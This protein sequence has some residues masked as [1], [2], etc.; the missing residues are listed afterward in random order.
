MPFPLTKGVLYMKVLKLIDDKLEEYL[1]VVLTVAMTALI[2]IQ[3]VMRYVFH[4]SPA[5][6]EELSRYLFLWAIWIGA[7]YGVK[8][9]G[10][11][12]L[13]IVTGKLSKGLQDVVGSLVWIIWVLFQVFLVVKGFELVKMFFGTGQVSTAMHI[14]MWLAYAS[15][16]GGGALMTFRLLQNAW[17]VVRERRDAK[18]AE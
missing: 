11:V 10:H 7:S 9:K 3:V 17:Q 6:T 14:P 1:M 12:R 8:I 13:T 18:E 2:F 5:W 4:N 15:V 16:P